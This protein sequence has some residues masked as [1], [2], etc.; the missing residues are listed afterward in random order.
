MEGLSQCHKSEGSRQ[1]QVL[2][3]GEVD[4]SASSGREEGQRSDIAV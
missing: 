1:S 2:L 3:R 4:V